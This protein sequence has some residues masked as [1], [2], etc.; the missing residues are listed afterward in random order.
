M[1]NTTDTKN[2][3][4]ALYRPCVGVALF[5][6]EGKVFVGQRID[7]VQAWQMPQGG[8]DPGEDIEIAAKRE[9]QEETGISKVEVLRIADEKIRY[10]V[11]SPLVEN[12]WKGNFRGQE[13]VWVAM[14]FQGTDD[15]INL[16]F[17]HEP[18]FQAWQWVDL[19]ETVDLIVPFKRDVY[20]RVIELFEDL[21]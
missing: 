13:Q 5:N 6:Q 21:V 18:E 9:L 7:H 8:I 11:P 3:A 4:S 19:R 15:D 16:E 17:H 10:D 14:R 20:V 12:L 2:D 1:T